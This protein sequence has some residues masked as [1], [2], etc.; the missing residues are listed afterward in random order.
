[1][2]SITDATWKDNAQIEI[3]RLI[4]R[5]EGLAINCAGPCAGSLCSTLEEGINNLARHAVRVADAIDKIEE[6]PRKRTVRATV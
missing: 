5:L 6:K 1:M 2:R 4:A 3:S